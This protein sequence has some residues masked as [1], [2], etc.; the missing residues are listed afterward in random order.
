MK[1]L[2]QFE[3]WLREKEAAQNTII[4]YVYAMKQFYTYFNT[5][6]RCNTLQY[7]EMLKKSSKP[8]TVNTRIIGLNNYAEFI[9]RPDL[10]LKI[11]KNHANHHVENVITFDEYKYFTDRLK[12]D[13]VMK[14][15]YMVKFMA[16]TGCRVSELVRL[17]KS[18]LETGECIMWS[19]G[20]MRRIFIP[21]KLIEE[22]KD[23]FMRTDDKLLFANKDGKSLTINNIYKQ[24]LYHAERYG[25]RKEVVHPHSFRHLFAIQFLKNNNNLA[26]LRDIMG[27]ESINTTAIYLQLSLEE[28]KEAFNESVSWI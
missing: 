26:L 7:K 5:F 27:H 8:S 17:P 11:V 9:K 3:I 4:A 19:K 13:R 16:T 12:H 15:Y 18:C 22:C 14:V 1:D 6:D 25:I 24:I 2:K 28:Q 21:D 10:K 23:Y 20:K